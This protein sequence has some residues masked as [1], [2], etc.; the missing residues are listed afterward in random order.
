MAATVHDSM[1]PPRPASTNPWKPALLFLKHSAILKV[2]L[3]YL[4]NRVFPVNFTRKREPLL[5]SYLSCSLLVRETG[6]KGYRPLSRPTDKGNKAAPTREF[7]L[8]VYP[9]SAFPFYGEGGQNRKSQLM[10]EKLASIIRVLWLANSVY[11]PKAVKRK[12]SGSNS[13]LVEDF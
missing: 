7:S 11:L 9:A 5:V 3:K 2:P 6:I 1:S 4:S 8:D 10:M 13:V 12:G